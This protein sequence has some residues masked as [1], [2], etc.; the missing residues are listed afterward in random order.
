MQISDNRAFWDYYVLFWGIIIWIYA[1]ADHFSNS[2]TSTPVQ[3]Q[4]QTN[5]LFCQYGIDS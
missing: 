2:S 4:N 1:F 3:S 5:P